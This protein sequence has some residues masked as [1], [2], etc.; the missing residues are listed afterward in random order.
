MYALSTAG[1]E[2]RSELRERPGLRG[3]A[4]GRRAVL[5]AHARAVRALG[6]QRF[7]IPVFRPGSR[8]DA[9]TVLGVGGRGYSQ[10]PAPAGFIALLLEL[11]L[12]AEAVS[13]LHNNLTAEV[14]FKH[15][16][17]RY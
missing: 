14:T 5:R 7:G 11:P 6:N 13:K 8:R 4:A 2:A 10:R 12:V 15:D 17:R 16:V 3:T 9:E 1:P